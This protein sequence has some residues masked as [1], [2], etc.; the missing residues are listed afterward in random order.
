MA[1]SVRELPLSQAI[2][3]AREAK[4]WSPTKLAAELGT[5]ESLV[6]KWE[7][8]TNRP[9]VDRVEDLSRVLGWSLPWDPDTG[10]KLSL[11]TLPRP[12]VL[13]ATGR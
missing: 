1:T 10:R 7:K 12:K 3:A 4:G 8:G 6:R 13:A 5:S 2:R 11:A 9:S